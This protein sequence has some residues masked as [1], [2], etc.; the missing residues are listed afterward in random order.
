MAIFVK[1]ALDDGLIAVA[2]GSRCLFRVV[3]HDLL[4]LFPR[5]TYAPLLLDW[6][7]GRVRRMTMV[8]FL[9]GA[10]CAIRRR[11][12]SADCLDHLGEPEEVEQ[13]E[14]DVGCQVR[15]AEPERQ[16]TGLHESGGLAERV[17]EIAMV[18]ELSHLI[19]EVL[20]CGVALVDSPVNILEDQ[21]TAVVAPDNAT[22][23]EGRGEESAVDSLV[24]GTG[25][26][27]LVAEPVDVQ[28]RA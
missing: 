4:C 8:D 15:G 25:K 9:A 10:L 14:R 1:A 17:V 3:V 12:A 23:E 16:V 22:A 11:E 20:R 24:D 28:E 21:H 19:H 2:V 26:V 7:C 27:E 5:R 6:L 13:V 18:G